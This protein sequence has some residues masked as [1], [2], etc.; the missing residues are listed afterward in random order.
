MTLSLPIVN[1]VEIVA[2]GVTTNYY[3]A[4]L[5][6]LIHGISDGLLNVTK[7]I[8][9]EM[10]SEKNVSLGTSFVFI[11]G[12]I[13]KVMGTLMSGLLMGD[14]FIKPMAA[15]FPILKK[16]GDYIIFIIFLPF[17]FELSKINNSSLS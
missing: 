1:V 6:R 17:L 4:L 15:R 3:I 14:E 16:V 9:T 7:T 13:G 2:L 8:V 5:I 11:G 12:A 10:S